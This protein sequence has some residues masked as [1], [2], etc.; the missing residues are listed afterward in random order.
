MIDRLPRLLW[1]SEQKIILVQIIYVDA[2]EG[3]LIAAAKINE[4]ICPNLAGRCLDAG[5][6]VR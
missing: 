6:V 4:G 5:K 3:D 1:R 2:N